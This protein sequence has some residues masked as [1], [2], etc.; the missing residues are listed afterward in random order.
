MTPKRRGIRRKKRLVENAE[1][2]G[3]SNLSRQTRT[4]LLVAL[5]PALAGIAVFA[6]T[7]ANPLLY[8]DPLA[9]EMAKE[10][11]KQL[12]THRNGLTY[13]TIKLDQELW[14]SWP[15]GFHLANV[16]FHGAASALVALATVAL[17]AR[18]SVGL[19]CGLLFAVHPAHSEIVASIENRKEILALLFAAGSVILYRYSTRRYPAWCYAGAI[20]CVAL[21]MHAKEV[22]AVGMV[23]MLPLAGLLPE[24]DGRTSFAA[25]LRW[26]VWRALPLAI[27]GVVATGWYGGNVLRAFTPDAIAQNVD[28][29]FLSYP[30]VL[31]ASAASVPDVG[32]LL[33]YPA[34]LST[35]YSQPAERL[36]SDARAMVGALVIVGWVVAAVSAARWSPLL[37]FG[38]AWTLIMYLPASNVI[39]LKPHFLAERYLYVP[40]FGFCLVVAL[41]LERL[42][43]RAPTGALR[44]LVIALIVAVLGA[45]AARSIARNRD[46]RDAVS[47]WTA[48]LEATPE[49]SNKIHGM[50][51]GALLQAGRGKEAIPHLQRAVEAGVV[52]ADFHNN[53]ALAL[54]WD[55][56]PAEAVTHF[57]RAVAMVPTNP[58][59]R[60]NLGRALVTVGRVEEGLSH[61]RIVA[62]EEAWNEL[63]PWVSAPLAARGISPAELRATLQEWIA[64]HE[65][66]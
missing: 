46:W 37:A 4:L 12:A 55:G 15:A 54:E 18:P 43:A 17:G 5:L 42:R 9:L 62:R 61:L 30:E 32:R 22:A 38:L 58:L 57:E 64:A 45:G 51:G 29:S 39:P 19:L 50:L 44:A 31:S 41:G 16:L 52:E 53:L 14:G 26:T 63:Q 60:Y 47:L 56:R 1:K 33:I 20:A 2:T 49:S 23:V 59:F 28:P 8:D 27:F 11:L 24:A 34:R 35:H 48:A 3:R 10:P 40:S 13:L 21:G 7:L 25:R 6:N 65:R 36:L 66:R